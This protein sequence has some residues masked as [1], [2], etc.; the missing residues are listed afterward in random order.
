[1]RYLLFRLN[2]VGD[3]EAAEVRALLARHGIETYET[4]AGRWGFSVAAI[5][6]RDEA[7]FERGRE[8]IDAYEL[9]RGERVR[10]EYELARREGRA[11]TLLDRLRANPLETVM[12]LLAIALILYLSLWPFH[13]LTG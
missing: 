9:E 11:D 8:L 7:A 2:G 13:G 1:M 12:I 5:W 6:V 10:G 3:D 4:E